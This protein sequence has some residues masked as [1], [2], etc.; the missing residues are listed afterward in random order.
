MSCKR[1]PRLARRLFSRFDSIQVYLSAGFVVLLMTSHNFATAQGEYAIA[2]HGGAGKMPASDVRLDR[3]EVLNRLTDQGMGMLESGESALQVVEAIIRQLEDSE[4]FN[5]GRGC[6]LNDLGQHELDA[7][8]MDGRN[9]ACGAVAGIKTTRYPISLAKKVMLETRHVL[10]SGSGADDFGRQLG[11]EQADEK[12]FITERQRQRY[13]RWKKASAA[14]GPSE[15]E[16][17]S[18]SQTYFGTVGCVV[19]DR[20]G[21]LAAG[22]STG[23]LM[24]KRWGRIGDSPI[25]GAGN[26]A[27]NATCAVSGTGIGEEFIRHSVASDIAARMRYGHCELSQACRESMARL[28]DDCGGVICLDQKGNVMAHHNTPAMAFALAN[29][30]GVRQVQLYPETAASTPDVGDD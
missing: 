6:V 3:L 12:H 1:F 8:I 14:R 11:L 5:A 30:K 22:T 13:L 18:D 10:L 4:L 2:I 27:D 9:L 26:Y 29:S 20:N 23:G 17:E 19:L 16:S 15:N 25:I 7:S 28:P 21:N 24:G